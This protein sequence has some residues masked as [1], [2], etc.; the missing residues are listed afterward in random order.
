MSRAEGFAAI[1]NWMIRDERFDIYD[2]AVYTAL[3]SHTGP[4]GVRPSQATLAV[5]ARCSERKVR[6]VLPRLVEA[7][8]LE[9]TRRRR[10]GAGTGRS[11]A[12][13][14]GYVLHPHGRLAVDEEPARDAGT[15]DQPARDADQPAHGDR[16][17]GTGAQITPYIEEEP[18]E[19][20]PGVEEGPRKRGSRIPDPFVLTAEMK[21][22]AVAEVPGLDVVAHTR[23][24]V[25]HWRAET[26]AKATKRDWVAAW[27]NWMRKAH[28]WNRPRGPV[29]IAPVERA[30][31]VIDMGAHLDALAQRAGI[32]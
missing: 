26:G 24:F 13:T 4:G 27:R 22:W 30:Q 12:L 16:P 29:A 8:V 17:A 28:R 15:S 1:P 18:V 7:G 32:G 5:E 14:N 3:A 10:T 2:L 6:E 11:G 31:S 9:I 20:E 23:E 19:E 21:A 25:D